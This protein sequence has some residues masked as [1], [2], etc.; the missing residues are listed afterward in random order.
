[1]VQAEQDLNGTRVS[2]LKALNG[3]KY[4][5]SELSR[6]LGLSKPTILY[7]VRILENAGY[8]RRI[9]DGRKWVYYELTN[10]GRSVLRWRKVKMLLPV[11]A[12]ATALIATATM[13]ITRLGVQKRSYTVEKYV[14]R[15]TVPEV[16]TPK[17]MGADY[18]WLLIVGLLC[19]AT[20][21]LL[22]IYL[23]IRKRRREKNIF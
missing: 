8:V 12:G 20:I 4:T 19:V 11:A 16:G 7:H 18:T 13:A 3:R 9:D 1:M 2:I 22:A 6:V 14:P 10:S 15:E 21:V 5:V 17:A 23:A